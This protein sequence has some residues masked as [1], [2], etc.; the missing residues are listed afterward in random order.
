MSRDPSVVSAS[1][2]I[3]S[4]LTSHSRLTPRDRVLLH[5][6]DEHQTLLAD[7]IQRTL[8]THRRT[9]QLRLDVLRKLGFLDR[10]R[11]A[12]PRGGT[13]P[14]RWVLGLAGARFQAAATGRPLPTERAHAETITRLSVNPALRHLLSSN[15]FFVRLH[16]AARTSAD[17][18]TTSI[19]GTDTPHDNQEPARLH[20]WWS[21]HHSRA[22]FPQIAPDGHGIWTVEGTSVGFFLECDY[23]TENFSRLHAK[24]PGYA[25]LAQVGGP[26][27]P[28]LFWLPTPEREANLQAYLRTAALQVPVATAV[29]DDDPAEPVWMPVDGW[30]RRHLHELDCDHGPDSANNPNWIDGQLDLSDQRPGRR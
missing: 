18:R 14:W 22:R 10:F 28:V 19:T 1:A 20:R 11:F 7:Q 17:S 8:F 5:L 16:H 3:R 15:E 21:E 4:P 23:G 29:H 25:R 26:T 12:G 30:Q 13:E 24:L 2:I 6:L 27:Y 9:C